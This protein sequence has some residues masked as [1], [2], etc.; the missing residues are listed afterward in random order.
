MLNSNYTST[1]TS[2]FDR[3][4]N[5]YLAWT[6][7]FVLLLSAVSVIVYRARSSDLK[8]IL[9]LDTIESGLKFFS[10]IILYSPFV[11]ISL[12][13]TLDLIALIQRY[14]VHK[15]FQKEAQKNPN[16]SLQVLNPDALPNLGQVSYALIDKTGTLT[17]GDFKVRRIITTFKNYNFDEDITAKLHLTVKT[18]NEIGSKNMDAKGGPLTEQDEETIKKYGHRGNSLDASVDINF[19]VND[20]GEHYFVNTDIGE[21]KFKEELEA[22]YLD[23][24]VHQ[25]TGDIVITQGNEAA[26]LLKDRADANRLATGKLTNIITNKDHAPVPSNEKPQVA[27]QRTINGNLL[28]R[29]FGTEDFMVDLS[30]SEQTLKD[31]SEGLALCHSSRTRYINE[32]SQYSFESVNPEEVTLL[33]LARSM[34]YEYEYS[35]RPDNPSLYTVKVNGKQVSYNILGVNEFSYKRRRQSICI[36]EPMK[37]QSDPAILYVKG[38]DASMRDRIAFTQSELDV[39]NGIIED[40]NA[41]GF[42][43][44]VIARKRMT[45]E[46]GNDF[47]KKYQNYKGSLYSQEDGLEQLADEVENNL[48]LLGVIGLQDEPRQGA[49]Q[50]LDELRRSGIKTWMVTG[51]SM[52][53]AVSS[54]YLFGFVDDKHETYYINPGT[55]NEVRVQVRNILAQIKRTFDEREGKTAVNSSGK[56]LKSLKTSMANKRSIGGKDRELFKGTIVLSGEAWKVIL[57]DQYLYSNFSFIASIMGTIVAHSMTPLQKK[58]LILMIKSRIVKPHTVMAVGDGLND[59]LM[60]QA[61]D[62]GIEISSL[63]LLKHKHTL[64]AGDV[65]VTDFA[66]LKE[67]MLVDGRNFSNKMQQIVTFMFYKSYL[68]ALPLFY[69]NWYS[70]FTGTALFESMMI[71]LYPFLFTFLP[72]IVFGAMRSHESELVLRHLPGLY[73]DGRVQRLRAD[74]KFIFDAIVKSLVHS[75]ITFYLTVYCVHN[76]LGRDGKDAEFEIMMLVQYYAIVTIA[77]LD[78][79]YFKLFVFLNLF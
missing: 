69:F 31:L 76:S 46:E 24:D 60:L 61:A 19:A 72:V 29:P 64:N 48:E 9:Q 36:R 56:T 13:G 12:Y 63:S 17:T 44:V 40:N 20:E 21:L 74:R 5:L 67:L 8:Q 30:H 41:K 26:P 54:G 50:F 15:K 78:V 68:I 35:N 7:F 79:N 18:R 23:T 6:I 39:Y 42:R 65:K 38:S 16:M 73:V 11:P 43:T 59:T 22:R 66:P 28:S 47:Y 71:F 1:K 49:K 10:Y 45:A 53:Q 55:P 27:D 62:V 14:R 25:H 2:Y 57:A 37:T 4:T 75:G 33:K 58:K 34:G 52:E 3:H 32:T 77:T 70:S 51:D